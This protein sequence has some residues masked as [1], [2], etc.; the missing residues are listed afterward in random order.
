MKKY[1]I[2]ISISI[3]L[4]MNI[5]ISCDLKNTNTSN[6]K[7]SIPIDLNRNDQ[8][9]IF[10]VFS[11]IEIIPLETN[12]NSLL[13]FLIG[14]PDKIVKY[15]DNFYFLDKPQD[16]III[17]N[18]EGKFQR[19]ISQKGQGPN[20]YISIGDFNINR[21]T[22][23]LEILSPEGRYVNIYGSDNIFI[24]RIKLPRDLPVVH[25]FHLLIPDIYVFASYASDFKIFF[26][27]VKDNK[28]IEGDY[29][30]PEWFN[31][32]TTFAPASRNPFYLYNDTVCFNQIYN[33]DVFTLSPI[34]YD[35]LP[36]YSWD[37]GVNNFDP[38]ILPEDETFDYYLEL[39]KKI[40]I[41][42]AIL[43]QIY[44]ENDEYYFT[45][46]KFKNRYKH[47]ILNKN[48]H[49]YLLFERFKEGGQCLPQWI[50]ED[51]IY[52]F[53]SPGFLHHIIDPS[54]L[55]E[56]NQYKYSQIKEDDNPVIIKY[57]FK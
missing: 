50:D 37:F 38:S 3:L 54:F 21:F 26:Y 35:L 4:L 27:S 52:T 17:F 46:F 43:F 12:E 6:K 24:R 29:N 19:K 56:E 23:N 1:E 31:H 11:G 10:D 55:N 30:L 41:N 14:E 8:I 49:E 2:F 57:I 45:R 25:Q 22:G 48:T 53:V 20:E 40:S 7:E 16:A 15:N 51:A 39:L 9:S 28:I 32:K 47:L 42:Y 36:R 18:S 44:Q 34:D 13:T 33:G 5:F